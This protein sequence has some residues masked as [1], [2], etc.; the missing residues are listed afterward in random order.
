MRV[1]LVGWGCRGGGAAAARVWARARA[2]EILTGECPF[3]E[4]ARLVWRGVGGWGLRLGG[5]GGEDH[6][7]ISNCNLL[8]DKL[9]HVIG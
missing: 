7:N 9:S 3:Q 6:I 8:L 2:H 4:L 5:V 1:A